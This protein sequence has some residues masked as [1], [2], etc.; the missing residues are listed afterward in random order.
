[1]YQQR[2]IRLRVLEAL[3]ERIKQFRR[4]E[5]LFPLRIPPEPIL[6]QDVIE[7][8]VPG[9]ARRV[10]VAALRS[11]TLLSLEWDDG[12]VW[13]LWMTVLP[14][15][16]KVYCDSGEE[17]TRLLASGG[18]NEGDESDR[19]CLRL[20]AES[21]GA[22][23]GIEMAGGAPSRV[24]SS[25]ADRE[26]L[27]DVFVELFEVTAAEDSLRDQLPPASAPAARTEPSDFRNDVE[28]WLDAALRRSSTSSRES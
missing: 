14:S 1:V 12:S 13:E 22:H 18:R 17:E 19:V 4:R 5:E 9:D 20:L 16:F 3:E 11:R 21:A 6:L 2:Q 23:F 26:F 10:D 25:I 15:G 7:R 8:A 24:R 27:I 28:R